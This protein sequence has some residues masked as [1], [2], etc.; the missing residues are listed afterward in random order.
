M[1]KISEALGASIKG[2]VSGLIRG[3]KVAAGGDNPNALL[4]IIG[5]NFI[6]LPG[7]ARD[8]NVAR[9]GLQQL[10]KLEGGKAA[11]GADAQFL[12][13]GERA[14]KLEVEVAKE[15][16][17]TPVKVKKPS[18]FDKL[19]KQFSEKN[20][21][22]KL[23]KYLA[24]PVLLG[25]LFLAFKD[26]FVEW[27]SGLWETIKTK[28]DEFVQNIKQWFSD[29]IMP[30]VDKVKG[31]IDEWIVQPVKSF[32]GSLVENLKGVF[33]TIGNLITDPIGTIKGLWESFKNTIDGFIQKAADFYVN[34]SPVVK[35][36]VDLLLPDSVKQTLIE[37]GKKETEEKKKEQAEKRVK[38]TEAAAKAV[39]EFPEEEPETPSPIL[40]PG[41]PIKPSAKTAP[42]VSKPATAEPK[43]PSVPGAAAAPTPSVSGMDDVKAMV[44]KHEGIRYEPYKDSLGLWTVGVGHLIG[45]GKSLPPEYNRKFSKDEVMSMF[46]KDFAHHVE[47]AEKTPGYQQANQGGKAAFID[48]AFNMGKWWPKWPTTKKKLAEGDFAGA[49]QGLQDSRWYEQV[50]GRAKTIVALVAQAGDGAGKGGDISS[51]STAVASGQRQQMKPG[52]PMVVNAPTTNTQVVQKTQVASRRQEDPTDYTVNAAA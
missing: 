4:K 3:G 41:A 44:I 9:Q 11:T 20:I 52:T 39:S 42:T 13:E 32:F 25:G 51:T 6:A 15:K 34:L 46:E 5:K 38:E 45:D 49:A 18:K 21:G 16:A 2:K 35:K 10:V 26:S 17:P 47:I 29:V 27:A 7:F 14:A 31:F 22:T 43:T 40:V 36:G 33:T 12:K 50:K 8:L 30:M 1:A 19:K 24:L 48:L 28:F 37:K 23:L